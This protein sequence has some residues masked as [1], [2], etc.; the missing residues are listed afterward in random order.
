MRGLIYQLKSVWKDKFC[1]MSFLLPIIV[2]VVLRFVGTIDLSSL[3]ELHFGA[4]ENNL[5]A[6]TI[7]WLERYGSVTIYKTLE[8]LTASINEHSTDLI[9]VETDGNGIKTMVAG[10]ELDIYRQVADTIPALYAERENAEQIN[11]SILERHDVLAGMQNIFIAMTLIVAM[12][13]GCTFNAMN[14]I[15]EKDNCVD[16]VNQILAMT[17]SQYVI[18]KIFIGFVFGCLSA[19]MTAC[20]C[21]QLSLQSTF[22]MLLLI[23]L[24]AFVAALIGLFIGKFSENLMVGVVY[25]KVVMIVFMAVPLLSYLLGANGLVLIL[26]YFVPSN[27][28]FEGVMNLANSTDPII[29]K[30]MLILMAHCIVWFLLYLLISKRRKKNV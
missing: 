1:I 9:G 19:V 11:V 17:Y 18:Q 8:E 12:F 24:S 4:L 27:A 6:E 5:S 21:F 29:A 26:C 16:L 10:D 2:A 20:I 7:S 22:L 30:D 23:I 14:M 13:M 28:T 25:V 15:S 3:G